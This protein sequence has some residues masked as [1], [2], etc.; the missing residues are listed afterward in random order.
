MHTEPLWQQDREFKNIYVCSLYHSRRP[1]IQSELQATWLIAPFTQ[2]G[3]VWGEHCRSICALAGLSFLGG[4]SL[5]FWRGNGTPL[6]SSLL[7]AF[8][9][10]F[11]WKGQLTMGLPSPR[12]VTPLLCFWSEGERERGSMVAS[13]NPTTC[14][15]PSAKAGGLDVCRSCQDVWRVAL[16]YGT[17]PYLPI[18]FNPV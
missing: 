12:P 10:L 18:L 4:A 17:F 14:R 9:S 1:F 8:T 6:S 15:C 13:I 5:L 11:S 2:F 3:V 7:R 16:I